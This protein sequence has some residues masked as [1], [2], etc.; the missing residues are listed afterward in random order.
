MELEASGV[1]SPGALR[2]TMLCLH[3]PRGHH[4]LYA[5]IF[6]HSILMSRFLFYF[7]LLCITILYI[8]SRIKS[9]DYLH[10]NCS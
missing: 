4:N 6:S 2:N 10:F 1:Q 7:L 5:L 3:K 8:I 9:K